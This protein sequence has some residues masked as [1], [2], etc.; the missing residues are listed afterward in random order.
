MPQSRTSLVF[1]ALIA[2]PGMALP[3]PQSIVVHGVDLTVAP[4]QPGVPASIVSTTSSATG[5]A[6]L[7]AVVRNHASTP[8]R[9]VVIAATVRSGGDPAAPPRTFASPQL[10]TWIA[11]G[12]S[13]TLQPR[14]IDPAT[15]K[16]LASLGPEG[17]RAVASLVRVEF[18]DG[19]VWTPA[20]P[21][22]P[23]APPAPP[24]PAHAQS[25]DE[26]RAG[27][28]PATSP[29]VVAPRVV[30]SV[31]PRYTA[32]AMRAKI[33]GVVVVEAVVGADGTV[34]RARLLNSLD[35]VF[36]LDQE[37]L[38]AARQ[39]IFLPAMRHGEAIP[40]IV[41]FDLEFRLH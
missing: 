6:Y 40:T 17:A 31:T 10:V 14:L 35:P 30:R 22:Q 18:S 29:D 2:L 33:Q 12:E 36:G 41:T 4:P 37:A 28:I 39:W 32:D 8:I 9:S 38:A 1:L 34:L 11:P 16:E 27:A 5:G 19:T 21:R 15:L 25:D 26:F 13:Q 24:Q 23:P 20:E 7:T 3:A